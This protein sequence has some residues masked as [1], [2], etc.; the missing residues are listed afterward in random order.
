MLQ[1]TDLASP[2]P[3]VL[4]SIPPVLEVVEGLLKLILSCE[5]EGAVV[6]YRLIDG[7]SCE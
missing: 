2:T 3:R 7:F 5:D 4:E 1:V 6:R